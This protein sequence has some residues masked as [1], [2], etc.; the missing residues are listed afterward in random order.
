MVHLLL[1]LQLK[2]GIF[3]NV[4]LAN[5]DLYQSDIIIQLL[6]PMAYD[7]IAPNIFLNTQHPNGTFIDMNT[8]DLIVDGQAQAEVCRMK[9]LALRADIFFSVVSPQYNVVLA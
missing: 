1:N 7:G 9:G 3:K 2:S 6:H 8:N 4:N 5:A